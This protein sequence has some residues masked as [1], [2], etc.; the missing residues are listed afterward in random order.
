MQTLLAALMIQSANDAA[1]ALAEKIGGSAENFAD[2]M[3]QRA[4]ALG[5]TESHFTD[6]H[7]LP[8]SANPKADQHDVRRT[9]SPSSASS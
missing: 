4:K 1:E 5:L 6:P 3:N 9:T 2:I 7:G 8:N